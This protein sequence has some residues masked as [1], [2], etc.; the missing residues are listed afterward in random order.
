MQKDVFPFFSFDLFRDKV[1]VPAGY[2]SWNLFHKVYENDQLLNGNLKKARK[3]NYQVL[4]LETKNKMS[5]LH[6]QYLMKQLQLQY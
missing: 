1:E 2:I 3:I 6:W 5:I 4:I